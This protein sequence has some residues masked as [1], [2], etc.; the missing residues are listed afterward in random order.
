MIWIAHRASHLGS[1]L[2]HCS[3]MPNARSAAMPTIMARVITMNV[4]I[5]KAGLTIRPVSAEAARATT[6]RRQPKRRPND[7]VSM[8]PDDSRDREGREARLDERR[9][10][11]AELRLET[12]GCVRF[13]QDLAVTL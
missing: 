12:M 11:G 7:E 5:M 13:L 3:A 9:P 6:K 10:G 4:G 1:R 8:A 2:G